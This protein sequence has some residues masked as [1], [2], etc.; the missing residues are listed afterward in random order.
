MGEKGSTGLFGG[1]K[2]KGPSGA[3]KTK[4]AQT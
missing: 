3:D 2:V 4:V 1:M